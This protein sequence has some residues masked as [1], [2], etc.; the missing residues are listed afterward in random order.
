MRTINRSL[1]AGCIALSMTLAV[2]SDASAQS[3]VAIQPVAP[4][5]VGYTAERRG[6]FG[7]RVVYRPVLA[8]V[9]AA[10][11]VAP[12]VTA[13]RPVFA[14]P[15]TVNYAPAVAPVTVRYAPAAVRYAPAV[16]P[17]TVRYAPT[18]APVTVRY[19]PAVAPVAAY[20]VAP[21]PIVAP[22]RR[23]R[24]PVPFVFGF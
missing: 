13:A 6:L 9:A 16:A 23:Y 11:P 2:P 4:A 15:V 17:V 24:V 20:R 1:F 5:V 7:R 10:V 12:V 3:P 22:I 8:P 19:A 14:A 21:A 18:V